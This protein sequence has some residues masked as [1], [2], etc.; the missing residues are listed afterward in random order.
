MKEHRRAKAIRQAV[1]NLEV[2]AAAIIRDIDQQTMNIGGIERIA[3]RLIFLM[4]HRFQPGVFPVVPEEAGT[5]GVGK[6]R[7]TLQRPVRGTLKRFRVNILTKLA[8]EPEHPGGI[9]GGQRG[10]D[11]C[12]VVQPTPMIGIPLIHFPHHNSEMF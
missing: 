10:V 2:Q 4:H 9:P 11:Q 6:F 12:R 5:D 7:I 3:G 8:I 1:E